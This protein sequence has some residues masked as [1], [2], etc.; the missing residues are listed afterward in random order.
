[1]TGSDLRPGRVPGIVDGSM[2]INP[3]PDGSVS[4]R[5]I[6]TDGR[7]SQFDLFELIIGSEHVANISC[8]LT[9][10]SAEENCDPSQGLPFPCH[11]G[12]SRNA[13]SAV[14]SP[15][16]LRAHPDGCRYS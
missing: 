10:Q 15:S 5:V 4:F 2:T 8:A 13:V 3:E 14:P 6:I 1:M 9:G 16:H 12:I 7:T 11:V